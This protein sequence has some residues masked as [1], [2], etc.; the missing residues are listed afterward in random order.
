MLLFRYPNWRYQSCLRCFRAYSSHSPQNLPWLLP[1]LCATVSA[2][3]ESWLF[4]LDHLQASPMSFSNLCLHRPPCFPGSFPTESNSLCGFRPIQV[5]SNWAASLVPPLLLQNPYTHQ[6]FQTC[7]P[8]LCLWSSGK[9]CRIVT[10]TPARHSPHS[11]L[12]LPEHHLAKSITCCSL[13]NWHSYVTANTR[14]HSFIRPLTSL[15]TT[16]GLSRP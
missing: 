14:L 10:T 15:L 4:Y 11:S 5:C 1:A 13:C 7:H 16:G 6:P 12:A 8:C 9:Q 2:P 3:S